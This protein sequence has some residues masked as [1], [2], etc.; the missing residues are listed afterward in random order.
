MSAEVAQT[1]DGTE[2]SKF[3]HHCVDCGQYHE[4]FHAYGSYR[5]PD[6]LTASGGE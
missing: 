6:C 5:C 2:D 1:D 4:T 3:E